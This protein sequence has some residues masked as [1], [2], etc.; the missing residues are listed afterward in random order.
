[1]DATALATL[2]TAWDKF[3]ITLDQH[4]VGALIFLVVL[5]VVCRS[6]RQRS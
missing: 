1:M 3:V 5:I 6:L 4:R 2:V